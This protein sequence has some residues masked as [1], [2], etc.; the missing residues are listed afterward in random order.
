MEVSSFREFLYERLIAEDVID[1]LDYDEDDLEDYN[2]VLSLDDLD[3]DA[4]KLGTYAYQYET[5]CQDN[6]VDPNFEGFEEL[7]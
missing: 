1:P 2:T 6:G 7:A 5:E 4:E 3:L